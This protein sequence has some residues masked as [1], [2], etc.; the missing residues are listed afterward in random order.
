MPQEKAIKETVVELAEQRGREKTFCPSEAARAVEPGDWRSLMD[1]VRDAA[2]Q[3]REE[4]KVDIEQ[5]GEK[6]TGDTFSG[7][8]RLR[9][10]GKKKA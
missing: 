3:L 6:L 1:E 9:L 2:L 7:P 4:G 8:I 5:N 10:S